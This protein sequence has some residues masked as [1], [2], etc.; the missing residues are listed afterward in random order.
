MHSEQRMLARSWSVHEP[1]WPDTV[2]GE[3]PSDV[4]VHLLGKLTDA[5]FS[6]LG[7]A[8]N[9]LACCG[10]Q[11]VV[12]MIDDDRGR[13]LLPQFHASIKVHLVPKEQ[14]SWRVW[15]CLVDTLTD[16]VV[17][18][19]PSAVHVHGAISA[20]AAAR[21]LRRQSDLRVK[22]FFSPHSSKFL[23]RSG[24]MG[25]PLAHVLRQVYGGRAPTLIANTPW[26]ARSL[27]L[28]GHGTVELVE[29]PVADPFFAVHRREWARP[30]VLTGGYPEST[31]AADRY[32]QLSV[33]IAHGRNAPAFEWI[34][35]A[36][37]AATQRLHAAAVNLID[38]RSAAERARCMAVGWVYVAPITT[39]GF[40]LNVAEAMAAGLPCVA[41][42]SPA[43]RDLIED[44]RTGFLCRDHHDLARR[45]GQLLDG[46]TLRRDVG[47]AAQRHARGR[48][49]ERRFRTLALAAYGDIGLTQR[50]RDAALTGATSA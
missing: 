25:T 35:G 41:I 8:T 32:A 16:V 5:V 42:D 36:S 47:E 33:L 37:A 1:D 50:H 48:F 20:F 7:P 45:V 3:W 22:A 6:F 31:A 21:L 49:S 28:A 26:E 10:V 39:R 19:R 23:G 18:L 24:T 11:Q 12:V 30:R 44:G 29:C 34:G 2:P 46:R 4:V 38:A 13:R 40:A 17:Q 15:R 27:A 43:H 14:A 9:A